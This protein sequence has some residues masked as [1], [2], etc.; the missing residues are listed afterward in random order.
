[1]EEKRDQVLI[2][3]LQIPIFTV[4][5]RT[6]LITNQP[7]SL[8]STSSPST[9]SPL[10]PSSPNRPLLPFNRNSLTPPRLH[11][12]LQWSVNSSRLHL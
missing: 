9:R 7:T 8:L 2:W 6:S 4:V 10:T 11:S 3:T 12:R 5:H 1:M